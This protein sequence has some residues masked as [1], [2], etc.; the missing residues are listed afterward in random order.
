MSTIPRDGAGA[1]RSRSAATTGDLPRDRAG[2]R[3]EVMSSSD[4]EGRPV[5]N[6][7]GQDF[8][9]IE[10]VML[11]VQRGRIAYAVLSVAAGFGERH[12][13]MAV[14]WSVLNLDTRRRRF[15][16]DI[17]EEPRGNGLG[18]DE[19]DHWTEP[20]WPDQVGRYYGA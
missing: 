9:H 2:S 13:L 12:K 8:G 5:V 4:L 11:D 3:P 16:L 10:K 18:G 17:P 7:V 19:N 14:P 20:D 15:V 6:T 1:I